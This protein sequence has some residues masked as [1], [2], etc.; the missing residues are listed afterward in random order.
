MRK[1]CKIMILVNDRVLVDDEE[2]VFVEL[3]DIVKLQF[4]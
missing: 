2:G 4:I 1:R 3:G